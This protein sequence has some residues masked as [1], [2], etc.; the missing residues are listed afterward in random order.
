MA[1][2]FSLLWKI[3]LQIT[4]V[5]RIIE[6]NFKELSPSQETASCVTIQELPNILWNL[7]VHYHV[8]QS[9]HTSLS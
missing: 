3:V 6:T 2:H 9:L 1:V 5:K 7:K 4:V 8:H